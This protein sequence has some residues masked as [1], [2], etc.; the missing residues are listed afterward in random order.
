MPI[1][2]Y[3]CHDCQRR[4]SVFWRTFS[5]AEEGKATCPRCG[6][7]NL[8]RLVS[9]VRVMRSAG[10]LMDMDDPSAFLDDIDENDPRSL[11]R[12]MRQMAD[13]TGE[14]MGPEFDEVVGRL[15]AGEDPEKIEQSMPDLMG[16]MGGGLGLD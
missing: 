11:G 8:T 10:K 1:H 9:R 5:Q 14:D 16:D 4:V 7:D 15:E 12:M 3:H 13:E 6:G 2:E